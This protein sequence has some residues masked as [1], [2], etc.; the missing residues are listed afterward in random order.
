[1]L[2]G[3]LLPDALPTELVVVSN[4]H[5]TAPG[6]VCRV[7]SIATRNLRASVRKTR[8]RRY[9]VWRRHPLACIPKVPPALGACFVAFSPECL[10]RASS[11]HPKPRAAM[12]QTVCVCAVQCTLP[13]VL[14]A[15][16]PLQS[17]A[18]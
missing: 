5:I 14:S 1:M 6:A 12:A 8:T 11:R 4:C 2:L 10:H 17:G 9:E 13:A 7:E 3:T 18:E 15:A 16:A